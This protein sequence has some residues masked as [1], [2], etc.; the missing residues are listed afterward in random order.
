MN[1]INGDSCRQLYKILKILSLKAQFSP[2]L[3]FVAK[4]RDI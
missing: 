2:L 4:N 1:A 3:L